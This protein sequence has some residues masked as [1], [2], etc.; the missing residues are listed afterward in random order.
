MNKIEDEE[1]KATQDY[2]SNLKI[3]P[4]VL[5]GNLKMTEG[6]KLPSDIGKVICI[7][8]LH[9]CIVCL[10]DLGKIF[11]INENLEIVPIVLSEDIK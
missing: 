9:D 8:N 5:K 1:H 6:V 11:I 2:K 4:T 7:E 10:T 3:N